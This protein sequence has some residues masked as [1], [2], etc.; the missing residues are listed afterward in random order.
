MRLDKHQKEA[1]VRA[2]MDS[3]PYPDDA[4]LEREMQAAVVKAMSPAVRKVFKTNP[5]AL[6]REH[7][8]DV[9]ERGVLYLTV[10]DVEVDAIITKWRDAKKARNAARDRLRGA[11]AGIHTLNRLKAALPEME[12]YM[13]TEVEQTP[14]L[15]ALSGIVADLVKLGWKGGA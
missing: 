1:F 9:A 4:T 2:V 7:I 13:P 3:I 12:K 15:P 11:V 5:K 10:G 8:Y 14:N 6:V